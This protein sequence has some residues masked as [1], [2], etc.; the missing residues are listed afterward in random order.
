MLCLHVFEMCWHFNN[1]RFCLSQK[2]QNDFRGTCLSNYPCFDRFHRFL[3][4]QSKKESL[5]MPHIHVSI[6]YIEQHPFFG[7][8]GWNSYLWTLYFS[9][10][11][12]KLQTFCQAWIKTIFSRTN[13]TAYSAKFGLLIKILVD[14]NIKHF[15]YI[16]LGLLSTLWNFMFWGRDMHFEFYAVELNNGIL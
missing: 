13:D 12:S 11:Q 9:K 4:S 1:T 8:F 15:V 14:E 7:R 3:N 10:K 2:K 16:Q 6:L 5:N